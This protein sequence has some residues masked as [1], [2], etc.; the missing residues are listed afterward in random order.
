MSVP[1][2]NLNLTT[3]PHF[4]LDPYILESFYQSYDFSEHFDVLKRTCEIEAN[5]FRL[6]DILQFQIS[7]SGYRVLLEKLKLKVN[8]DDEKDPL[9]VMKKEILKVYQKSSAYDEKLSEEE[10]LK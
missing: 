3:R 9:N 1:Y 8:S 2:K 5:Y 6:H 7:L 4:A 10:T